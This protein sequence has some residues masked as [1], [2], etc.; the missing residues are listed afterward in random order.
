MTGD[1]SIRGNNTRYLE[2]DSLAGFI[3]RT[4]GDDINFVSG[5]GMQFTA[6]GDYNI[7]GGNLLSLFSSTTLVL[8]STGTLV[9]DLS[10]DTGTSGEVLGSNGTGGVVWGQLA[11]TALSGW[12]SNAS[13]VLTNNGSG[14]LSWGAGGGITSSGTPANTYLATWTSS[15]NLT[16][17]SSYRTDQLNEVFARSIVTPTNGTN[18]TWTDA[19]VYTNSGANLTGNITD[20]FSG[21]Q[22]IGIVQKIYH[23]D[24]TPPTFPANWVLLGGSYVTNETNI[25]YCEWFGSTRVEYWIAQEQ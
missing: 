16:G 23:E 4:F 21:T 1:V 8:G 25:I 19:R 6:V 10:S 13:G 24:S 15:T 7:V 22:Y 2:F 14:T 9:V 17:T 11:P 20:S 18:I 5:G 3:L 12:P